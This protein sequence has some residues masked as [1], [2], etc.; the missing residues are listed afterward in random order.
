MSYAS[1]S[2]QSECL[3]LTT[4]PSADTGK[5][6]K[7]DSL[8]PLTVLVPDWKKRRLLHHFKEKTLL[9]IYAS[10]WFYLGLTFAEKELFLLL[11][12]SQKVQCQVLNTKVFDA[13]I[14]TQIRRQSEE[15]GIQNNDF[16]ELEKSKVVDPSKLAINQI[17]S[18]VCAR[19]CLGAL[20]K[21][22]EAIELFEYEPI[23]KMV[24]PRKDYDSIWKLRSF[25]SLRDK[26]FSKFD[27]AKQFGKTGVKRP[28]IRGYTDGRGKSGDARRTKMAREVDQFFWNDLHQKQWEETFL[29]IQSIE[30]TSLFEDFPSGEFNWR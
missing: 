13:R 21:D 8:N 27:N 15:R 10:K 7:P 25:Q 4:N 30:Q 23:L 9:R 6:L 20:D 28:R 26:L 18:S 29:F 12:E 11:L 2:S 22:Q 24:Y 14:E 17:G 3:G 19:L 5:A 1:K 16:L